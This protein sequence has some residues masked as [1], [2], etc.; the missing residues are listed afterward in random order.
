MLSP[1]FK[2]I[3]NGTHL[4]VGD[5]FSQQA[6]RL[7]VFDISLSVAGAAPRIP[8]HYKSTNISMEK[9]IAILMADLTGYTALTETHG[10][11]AAADVIDRY[12]QIAEKC[13]VGDTQIHERR[14]DEIMFVA[15]SPEALLA[16][17][18]QLEANTVYEQ[19][20]LQV[21]GGLHYGKVFMR[22]DSYFG[23]AINMAS[24]I[25]GKASPGTFWCSDDFIDAI[26][27]KTVYSFLSKG[28]H[29]FKNSTTEMEVFEL[30]VNR[31]NSQAVDPICRMIIVDYQHAIYYH[32][33]PRHYFCS[34]ECLGIYQKNQNDKVFDN[35]Q[36]DYSKNQVY[37]N[38]N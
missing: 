19:N 14:G 29:R 6:V 30:K 8:L 33:R 24:R 21:H 31:I 12:I 37:Y 13:L 5:H 23:A 9:N 28:N 15:D 20:F 4:L 35:Q 3:Q 22:A 11:I 34:S 38:P 18:L 1:A 27:D 36:N 16:T 32:D 17:A 2:R 7:S 26:P 10:P 25:A